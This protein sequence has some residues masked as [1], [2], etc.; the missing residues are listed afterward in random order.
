MKRIIAAALVLVSSWVHAD[1]PSRFYRGVRATAMG[2]AF[3]AI[4]DDEQALYLNPAGLAGINNFSFHYAPADFDLS[5]D[6]VKLGLTGTSAFSNLGVSSLNNFMGQSNTARG[7]LTP[8]LLMANFGF[9]IFSEQL[10][11]ISEANQANPQLKLG[12]RTTNGFQ[13]GFAF[14]PLKKKKRGFKGD[15]RI[16]A[17]AKMVWRRGGVR[18]LS[19]LDV[20]NLAGQGAQFV[21]AL[22]GSF[23]NSIG[24][25]LGAQYLHPLTKRVTLST[26]LVMTD[27]GNTS[28]P[29]S[30]ADPVKAD[31]TWGVGAKIALPV[32]KLTFA[33][34]L[35]SLN[36]TMDLR[37]RSHLGAELA[38]PLLS[39][40]AGFYQ[41]YFTY[42]V[43]SDIWL[44]KLQLTS[45]SEE[46][47]TYGGQKGERRYALRA[48]LKFGF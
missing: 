42:G 32:G 30:T 34:D 7:A 1:E 6:M 39:I 17:A 23:G 43:G 13:V 35:K 10:I 28:F 27:I 33:Y 26:G 2:G 20:M 41:G 21:S 29:D 31:L 19:F 11:Q 36:E 46:Q 12:Y 18:T 37:K 25:D 40:Q 3:V 24:Y 16:G 22:A 47:G 5:T 4:A 44:A 15:L 8:T 14:A 38:V 48:S 45:Y 9:G